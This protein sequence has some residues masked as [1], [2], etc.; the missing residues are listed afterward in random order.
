MEKGINLQ[1]FELKEKLAKVISESGLPITVL[2]MIMLELSTQ[3]NSL[4][5][6]QIEAEK[7]A[8]DKVEDKKGE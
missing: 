1:I 2:Q 5:S 4:A 6:Q 3:I 7:Q 8:L